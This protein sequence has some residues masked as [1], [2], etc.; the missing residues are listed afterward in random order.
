MVAR[1]LKACR[2][3]VRDS[4]VELEEVRGGHGRWFDPRAAC[5]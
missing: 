1:S 5:A 2:R 4:G 3:A